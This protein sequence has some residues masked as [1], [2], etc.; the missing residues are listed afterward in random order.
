MFLTIAVHTLQFHTEMAYDLSRAQYVVASRSSLTF[1]VRTCKDA[2]VMLFSNA[3]EMEAYE[4]V[5]GGSSN[6]ITGIRARRQAVSKIHIHCTCSCIPVHKSLCKKYPINSDDSLQQYVDYASTPD[7]L[8]CNESRA[9]WVSWDAG[10]IRV[11]TGAVPDTEILVEWQDPEP[12]AVV[13]ASF[14]TYLDSDGDWQMSL[15]PDESYIAVTDSKSRHHDFA[16]TL[17]ETATSMTF[18]VM[19]CEHVRVFLAKVDTGNEYE[20]R[21]GVAG[22]EKSEYSTPLYEHVRIEKN[23]VIRVS[24]FGLE[25]QRRWLKPEHRIYST[26][27]ATDDSTCP[28]WTATSSSV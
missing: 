10:L 22:N 13:I 28:G 1:K 8:H 12:Q 19:G 11:G 25:E 17:E 24:G 23:L 3:A 27:R 9:F 7:I 14:S 26:V 4:V 2:H 15:I 6:T 21:L 5:I 16:V 20:I 18:D